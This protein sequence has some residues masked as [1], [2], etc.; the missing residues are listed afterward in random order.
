MKLNVKAEQL[1][2]LATLFENNKVQLLN[3]FI[4]KGNNRALSEDLVQETFMRVLAY[5]TSFSGSS[6]F[7]SWM[8]GIARNTVAEHYRKNKNQALNCDMDDEELTNEQTLCK[9]SFI[10]ISL[11]LLCN[12]LS[13][14]NF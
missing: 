4:R 3:Y 13:N 12:F 2:K 7:K 11:F 9:I 14:C 8:Y 1:D 10:I 5:R 6:T